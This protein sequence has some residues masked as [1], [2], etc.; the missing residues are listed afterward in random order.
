MNS[1]QIAQLVAD[2]LQTKVFKGVI[3]WTRVNN[4]CP[5]AAGDCM[6]P[7]GA[8][9]SLAITSFTSPGGTPHVFTLVAH[10]LVNGDAVQLTAAT[11]LSSDFTAN[12]KYFVCAKTDDTFQLEAT[13][14]GGGVTGSNAG[15]GVHTVHHL[16]L[17]TF[18]VSNFGPPGDMI[19]ILG[20][21]FMSSSPAVF[22]SMTGLR[23]HLYSALPAS[24][25]TLYDGDSWVVA[26]ADFRHYMGYVDLGTLVDV[27]TGLF[28]QANTLNKEIMLPSGT[29]YAI[30]VTT[31][32][33]TP[34]TAA[35]YQ[36]IS[37]MCQ[38]VT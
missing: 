30:P 13:V 12:A 38:S 14:G 27:G 4:L 17:A 31:A 34:T 1:K 28:V 24:A 3:A 22:T 21:R 16:A 29:L 15:T 9:G 2:R 23:L 32:A 19:R 10:G 35:T 8:K 5:Y 37:L 25:A 33:A 11:T 7:A 26:A 20:S 6:G 36:M 18:T